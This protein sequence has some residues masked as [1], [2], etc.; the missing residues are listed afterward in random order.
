MGKGGRRST[1]LWDDVSNYNPKGLL[2]TLKFC[3]VGSW[4]TIPDPYS[5]MEDVKEWAKVTRRLKGIVLVAL[6]NG[7]LFFFEFESTVEA[8]KVCKKKRS[9]NG[10]WV[11]WRGFHCVSGCEKSFSGLGIVVEELLRW[12]RKPI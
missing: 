7:E 12:T 2:G 3:L 8:K 4:K 5:A 1:P 6:L 9:G 11:G 10:G